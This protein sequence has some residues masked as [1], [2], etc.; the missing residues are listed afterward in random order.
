MNVMQIYSVCSYFQHRGIS[1]GKS[2]SATSK[3]IIGSIVDFEMYF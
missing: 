2:I 1:N 3:Q